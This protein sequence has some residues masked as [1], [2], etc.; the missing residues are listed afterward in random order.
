VD[1]PTCVTSTDPHVTVAV[2]TSNVSDAT[3]RR[4]IRRDID[5]YG[6]HSDLDIRACDIGSYV[7]RSAAIWYDIESS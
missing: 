1:T 2:V 6:C 3:T 5:V 4:K 7:R